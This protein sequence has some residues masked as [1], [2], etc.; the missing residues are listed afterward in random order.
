[1]VAVAAPSWLASRRWKASGGGTYRCRILGSNR[2]WIVGPG[3]DITSWGVIAFET[4][5]L[6]KT[7][8]VVKIN[9]VKTVFIFLK[10]GFTKSGQILALLY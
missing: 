8:K 7:S 2:T 9:S 1:M 5:V 3:S 4:E 6:P 10:V